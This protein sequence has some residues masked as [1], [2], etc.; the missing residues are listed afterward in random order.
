MKVIKVL[1]NLLIAWRSIASSS[2]RVDL[3]IF[4][5]LKMHNCLT[6]KIDCFQLMSLVELENKILAL[7]AAIAPSHSV[8]SVHSP[9]TQDAELEICTG[10]N[11]PND[12]IASTPTTVS[13]ATLPDAI[14]SY[15]DGSALFY[16]FTIGL[17]SVCRVNLNT[18]S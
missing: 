8:R 7:L 10:L 16:H 17:T 13:T 3:N 9:I 4:S 15:K 6:T 18:A 2:R 14:S 11:F 12:A 1:V 5:R